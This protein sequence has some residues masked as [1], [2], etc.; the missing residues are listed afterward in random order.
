MSTRYGRGMMNLINGVDISYW[1]F[2]N[3]T[4]GLEGENYVAERLRREG[5]S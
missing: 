1:G 4:K 5:F 2:V 3:F